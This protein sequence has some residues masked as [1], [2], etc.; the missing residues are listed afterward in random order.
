M[1][2]PNGH[3]SLSN[4]ALAREA[5]PLGSAILNFVCGPVPCVVKPR[6]DG[7]MDVKPQED[8]T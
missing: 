6:N 1:P 2:P 4:N 7:R 5:R 3:G 8:S